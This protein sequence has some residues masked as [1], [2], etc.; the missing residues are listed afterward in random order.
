MAKGPEAK[1]KDDIRA[2]LKSI[3]AYQFWP[4]QM[5]MGAATVDCLA[6]WKGRFFAIEVKRPDTRPEPT[7]RQARV[8][9]EVETAGGV[10]IV[11]FTLADVEER[12]WT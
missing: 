2:Y 7:P 9:H 8:L 1:V 12:L 10:S 4:V 5:G 3:G 6:C 11:A